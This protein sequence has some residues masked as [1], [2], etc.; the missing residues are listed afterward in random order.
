MNGLPLF[1]KTKLMPVEN[2]MQRALSRSDGFQAAATGAH[3]SR[4]ET[5]HS[6]KTVRRI[7]KRVSPCVT[8]VCCATRTDDSM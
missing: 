2:D 5:N 3:R 8:N 6:N 1:T 4:V 7:A